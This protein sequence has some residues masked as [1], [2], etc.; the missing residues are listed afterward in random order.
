MSIRSPW[1]DEKTG[2]G[3]DI[4]RHASIDLLVIETGTGEENCARTAPRVCE[5]GRR[6]YAIKRIS[7]VTSV[8]MQSSFLIGPFR[9]LSRLENRFVNMC[10]SPPT[11]SFQAHFPVLHWSTDT[12]PNARINR[13]CFYLISKLVLLLT[14]RTHSSAAETPLRLGRSRTD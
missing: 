9:N 7:S 4:V 6:T 13:F 14:S 2:C 11:T 12:A 8:D 10:L 1:V 5:T 3:F